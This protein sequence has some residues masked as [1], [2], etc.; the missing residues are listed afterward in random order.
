SYTVRTALDHLLR[1]TNLGVTFQGGVTILKPMA[2]AP[3]H[4]ALVN[5]A[6]QDSALSGAAMPDRS[7]GEGTDIIVTGYRHSLTEAQNLKR[8]AVG[9]E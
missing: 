9:N 6:A 5:V 1:G 4:P 7:V 3:V 8:R 2:A